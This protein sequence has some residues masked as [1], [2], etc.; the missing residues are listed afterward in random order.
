M[1]KEYRLK[2]TPKLD[3]KE[4][5][6]HHKEDGKTMQEVDRTIHDR[7][8]HKGGVSVTKKGSLGKK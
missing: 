6:W 3:N 2:K 7:F 4:T 5:V 8:T 1:L